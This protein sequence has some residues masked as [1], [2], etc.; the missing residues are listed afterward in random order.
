MASLNKAMIIGNIGREPELSYLPNGDGVANFSV[1]TNE[2]WTDK[3]SG[4]KKQRTEWFNVVAWRRLA[5]TC[6]EYLSK[7]QQVY[8]EG[9]MQT[10]SWEKDGQKHYR[11]E[12]VADQV[13]FLGQRTTTYEVDGEEVEPF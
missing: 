9:K 13:V 8:V 12:L 4:E 7:G 2:T 10:R 3:N 11:T 1:A 5:E 6:A